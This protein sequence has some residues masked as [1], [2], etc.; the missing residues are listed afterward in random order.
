MS[1]AKKIVVVDDDY[2]I[3]KDTQRLISG[4][5]YQVNTLIDG[6]DLLQNYQ[7]GQYDAIV[8][9]TQM[10]HSTGYEVCKE[11]RT[12][13][14]QIVII[15]MSMNPDY[16]DLWMES[17]ANNFFSKFDILDAPQRLQEILQEHLQK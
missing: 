10:N 1:E 4:F 6:R 11:L 3:R 13:D 12:R 9:D 15:G 7:P 2:N 14:A 17:G 16:R 5:G 8:M